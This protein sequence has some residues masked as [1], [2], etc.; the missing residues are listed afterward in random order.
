MPAGTGC[1]LAAIVAEAMGQQGG[2]GVLGSTW[3]HRQQAHLEDVNGGLQTRPA[4]EAGGELEVRHRRGD[5][6][7]RTR[8]TL[9]TPSRWQ[10]R[11]TGSK[12]HRHRCRACTLRRGLVPLI[13]STLAHLVD[14]AHHHAPRVAGRTHGVHHNAGGAGIQTRGGLV[15]KTGRP[16]GQDRAER[17]PVAR[18]AEPLNLQRAPK[19]TACALYP[20][21]QKN[22]SR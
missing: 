1:W 11:S 12:P 15:C 14:G 20:P 19:P 17:W 9:C 7:Q 2:W 10:L 5:S 3:Q 18:P 21:P 16:G 4:R 8:A 13:K 22:G 6:R